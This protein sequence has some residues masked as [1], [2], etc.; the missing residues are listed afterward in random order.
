MFDVLASFLETENDNIRS[1]VNTNSDKAGFV[2]S[3]FHNPILIILSV[4]FVK[5]GNKMIVLCIER[6]NW[7]SSPENWVHS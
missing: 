4:Q 2:V 1:S 6:R 3:P 5:H 7:S